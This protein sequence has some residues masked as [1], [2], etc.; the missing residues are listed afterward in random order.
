MNTLGVMSGIPVIADPYWPKNKP[1]MGTFTSRAHPFVEW[2]AKFFPFDPN[3]YF[4]NVQIGTTWNDPL[5]FNG[6]IAMSLEQF[7]Q[8]K[9]EIRREQLMNGIFK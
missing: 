6:K 3:T 8:L 7:A 2:L 5:M 1:V 4:E 9:D